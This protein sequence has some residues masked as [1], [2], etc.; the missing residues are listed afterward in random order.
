MVRPTATRRGFTLVELLVVIAIIG[1]LVALLLPAVQA[2]R[3]AAR[4]SQCINNMRQVTVA[5]LNYENARNELPP[6]Y[7]HI[8]PPGN[9]TG[10]KILAHGTQIYILPYM[11]LQTISSRYNF[12]LPWS[13]SS[14]KAVV[15]VD[16]PTFV[17]P[18]AVSPSERRLENPNPAARWPSGAYS[19]Y[20]ING[21]ISPC[22]L[23]VLLTPDIPVR[24][25]W[26]H[27]FTGVPE[28]A[29]FDSQCNGGKLLEGQ[30]GKSRLKLCTDGLSNTVMW[31][32]DV[33]RPDYW[34]DGLLKTDR[35]PVGGSRWASPDGEYWAHEVC[36][37]G[38]SMMNC[39]NDNENY[40]IHIGGGLYSFADGSVH[41]LADQMDINL[42]ISVFTRA[43]DDVVGGLQ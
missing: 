17:C 6:L 10:T 34:E 36:A 42:Q 5:T 19:D 33:G 43:G 16:I 26:Q 1:V 2:A 35:G 24:S 39:N 22:G 12:D 3:E 23:N 18:S 25:D 9:P 41:F 7:V 38:N 32:P 29:N 13:H 27:L 30:D 11:E 31:A 40:D 20:A 21:R 37:G 8:P 28:Y 14:N 15:D 4:R